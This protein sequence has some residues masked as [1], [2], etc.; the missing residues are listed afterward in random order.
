MSFLYHLK[1]GLK[2]RYPLCCILQFALEIT[3]SNRAV[4][5]IKRGLLGRE[6]VPCYFHY[7]LY[8]LWGWQRAW[9]KEGNFYKS[10]ETRWIYD[11]EDNK[12]ILEEDFVYYQTVVKTG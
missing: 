3:L 10:V 2:E 4:P 6:W 9:E 11:E 7:I 8:R 1:K 12:M 5:S